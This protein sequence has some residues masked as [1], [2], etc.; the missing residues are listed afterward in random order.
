MCCKMLEDFGM[1]WSV[2]KGDGKRT[3]V[4]DCFETWR[5]KVVERTE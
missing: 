4:V 1:L 5:K 2:V 3:D